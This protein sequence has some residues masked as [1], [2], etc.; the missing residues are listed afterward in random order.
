MIWVIITLHNKYIHLPFFISPRVVISKELTIKKSEGHWLNILKDNWK[1]S[2]C[3]KKPDRGNLIPKT[4]TER[5]WKHYK[6]VFFLGRRCCS[7]SKPIAM[8][9]S[10]DNCSVSAQKCPEFRVLVWEIIWKLMAKKG[11]KS[12]REIYFKT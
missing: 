6:F 7:N 3:R 9:N 12:Q 11:G 5:D 10:S 2:K 1:I 8:E 4:A